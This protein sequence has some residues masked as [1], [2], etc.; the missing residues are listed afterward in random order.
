[1]CKVGENG[2]VIEAQGAM[3]FGMKLFLPNYAIQHSEILAQ[4]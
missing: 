1:M 2:N 4:D 3:F